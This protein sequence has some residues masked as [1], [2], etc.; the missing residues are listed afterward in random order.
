MT[1]QYITVMDML[2]SSNYES[3]FTYLHNEPKEKAISSI[4][5]G[6]EDQYCDLRQLNLPQVNGIIKLYKSQTNVDTIHTV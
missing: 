5:V 1:R 3:Y 2:L 4:S 6:R